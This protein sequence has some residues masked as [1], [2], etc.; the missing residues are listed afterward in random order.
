MKLYVC[1]S[2]RDGPLPGG[3][4][5]AKAQPVGALRTALRPAALAA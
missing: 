2:T 5:C 1:Y 3:H 4:P